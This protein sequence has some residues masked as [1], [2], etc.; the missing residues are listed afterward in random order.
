MTSSLAVRPKTHHLKVW[1]SWLFRYP[2]ATQTCSSVEGFGNHSQF[3]DSRTL[4]ARN[5]LHDEAVGDF[6]RN[7]RAFSF[8]DFIVFEEWNPNMSPGN[9][10]TGRS[11]RARITYI[12]HGGQ[13]GIPLGFCIFTFKPEENS[14][15]QP[16]L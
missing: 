5:D 12:L 8:G 10:Y 6:R 9:R 7:D 1:P 3:I 2:V 13:F 15:R 11:F 4:Y 16:E 14:A